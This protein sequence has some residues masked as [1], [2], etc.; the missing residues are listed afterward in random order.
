MN[1]WVLKSIGL[2][3]VILCLGAGTSCTLVAAD[4]N[5]PT[6]QQ[7][8]GR[9]SDPAAA[10]TTPATTPAATTGARVAPDPTTDTQP[11]AVACSVEHSTGDVPAPEVWAE[12]RAE[13]WADDWVTVAESGPSAGTEAPVPLRRVLAQVVVGTLVVL[14]AVTALLLV[15]RAPAADEPIRQAAALLA[16]PSDVAAQH[17]P[18]ELSGVVTAAEPDWEGKFFLQDASGGVFVVATA[19]QPAVGDRIAV[20]GVTSR[21]AFAPVVQQGRWTPRGRAPLPIAKVLVLESLIFVTRSVAFAIPGALGVQ[22]AAYALLGPML[23]LP[24]PIA[25]ALSLAKRARDITVGA[26]VLVAWQVGEARAIGRR[27]AFRVRRVGLGG[28]EAHIAASGDPASTGT[29][30]T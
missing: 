7:V 21:G 2:I 8:N 22:E 9:P 23:G 29:E 4:Q 30:R 24:A 18:V 28:S 25:L 12:D 6:A 27:S 15:P 3:A 19:R 14:V 5:P 13:D 17:L 11:I 20:E 1:R 10:R 16:L 26:P